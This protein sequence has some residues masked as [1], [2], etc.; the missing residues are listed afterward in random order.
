[1][2]VSSTLFLA[3]F[4]FSRNYRRACPGVVHYK[5]FLTCFSCSR[6]TCTS[7][8]CSMRRHSLEQPTVSGV[9]GK[10]GFPF[11]LMRSCFMFSN[12]FIQLI[13]LGYL[14]CGTLSQNT[15]EVYLF[16]RGDLAHACCNSSR[17]QHRYTGQSTYILRALP[18]CTPM[19]TQT[20]RNVFSTI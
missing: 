8:V 19:D 13:P 3:Y 20:G 7:C 14:S 15:S 16:A 1:M 5:P 12:M 17:A 4:S 10:L 11:S 18:V 2:A 6:F 9:Q